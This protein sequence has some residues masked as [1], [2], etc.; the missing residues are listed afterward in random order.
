MIAYVKLIVNDLVET[1]KRRQESE[2]GDAEDRF[3]VLA[4]ELD[5]LD[6]RDFAPIAQFPFTQVRR[7]IRL[8]ALERPGEWQSTAGAIPKY[9]EYSQGLFQRIE[10]IERGVTTGGESKEKLLSDQR[11][12]AAVLGRYVDRFDRTTDLL[13]E[14]GTLLDLYGGEGS[15]AV[16]RSFA[17]VH[18][19]ELRFIIER[20]YKEL[21]HVLLPGTAWKSTVVIA[22]SILE[23]ILY[24]L[25]TRDPARITQAMASPKAPKKKGGVPKD[26]TRDTAEDEW[27]LVNLI[28][29]SA[30]LNL[31]P[32][33][34]ADAIDQV[35]RDYRNFVH[36]RKEI[37]AEHPC[38]EAE[39]MLAKGALDAVCN[40]LQ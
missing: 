26:I 32:Q 36:P 15:Q 38:T 29:V 9:V 37:K 18:N 40:H 6:P 16:T 30:D 20:D 10:D 25:L 12:S 17:F 24:D 22:G 5:R 8:F 21:S 4:E 3:R 39:A 19:T 1:L 31:I 13:Q 35:L 23:A 2:L 7:K 34:R 27:K 11:Q 14:V 28:E 33:A